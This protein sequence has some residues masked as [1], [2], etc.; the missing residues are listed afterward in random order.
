MGRNRATKPCKCLL[1]NDFRAQPELRHF[2][3]PKDF[4]LHLT[5]HATGNGDMRTHGGV[6]IDR[7]FRKSKWT[8]LVPFWIR[9]L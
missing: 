5:C 8:D 9:H 2:H 7:G 3:V 4:S 6:I 1:G